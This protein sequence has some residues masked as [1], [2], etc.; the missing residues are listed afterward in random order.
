MEIS[1]IDRK[2]KLFT[3]GGG[4]LL[5]QLVCRRNKLNTLAYIKVIYF[6]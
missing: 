4:G 6:G 1:L 2:M 3:A 5:F